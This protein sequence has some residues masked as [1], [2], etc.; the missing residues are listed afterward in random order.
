MPNVTITQLPAAG[1][2]TGTESVA[3]VQ[4]GQTL[5]TTT[6]AI[7][8]SPSQQQTFLTLNQEPTLPNSRALSGGAGVGLV[9]G[10]A[11]STLQVTL[12]GASGSLEAAANGVIV[13]TASNAVT[14]R[15]I[16]ATGPGISVTNGSGVAGDPTIALTGLALAI[17]NVGGTG[18]LSVVGGATIGGVQILG[19]AN[20]IDVA[21]GA[22]AGNPTIALAAN[23]VLPGTASMTVPVG[24]SAQQPAGLPGQLRFNA[25]TQ[26]FDGYALGQWRQFSVTGGVLT[27]SA[28]A[29]GLTPATPTSG[30]VTLGGILNAAH[31][32]T[33]VN[34]GAAT[35]TLGGNISTANDFIT[36]GA[37]ITLM[38]A[39]ATN[40]TLPT[41]GTLATL[42]GVEVLTN[43]TISGN[44]NT[45]TNI[46]NASLTNSSVTYNGVTVAL[47]A[48]GTITAATPNA[49]TFNDSGAG[50]AS[51]T[52]FDGSAART[53]S[54][55]TVGA[56]PLAGSVSLTTL[57]T[58]TTGTWNATPIGNSY[59]A[60]SAITIGTTSISLGG[61]SLTLGGLTSVAV[62][63]DPVSALQ[64]ATK[65]YV[66]A[67][68]EGLHV[69]AA[70]AAA[71]TGTLASITGGT[72]TYN[73]GSAGVG[74]TLTLSNALTTLDGYS[75][76]NGDRVLVK[77]EATTANNG[78]YT[79]A[80]GGTVLTRAPD[81][82][83]STEIAGGDFTFVTNGTLYGDTGWVQTDD[84][85]VVGTSP[86]TFIQF[87]GAGTYTAGTG[88]TLTGSQFSL[89]VPVTA[90]LGGTG[91]TS[92][93]T[94]DLLYATGATALSKLAIGTST[95]ILT[96]TGAAP[97]WSS[98]SGVTV[99]TATNLAGGAAGSVPYQ[100][101][102]GA[103]S[104][105]AIGTAA[106]VLQVNAGATAPE[107]VSS[108]GT[109]NV[110]R[111]TSPTL[112]TPLLGTPTSGTLTNCTG[113]PISTGVAGLGANVATFLATPTSAN[114]AAAVTNETGSGA[115]VFGTSP[116]IATPTLTGDVIIG[117]ENIYSLT[118]TLPTVVDDIVN[119]GS[120]ALSNGV[121]TFRISITVQGTNFPAA[122]EYAFAVRWDLTAGAW[123]M[124]QPLSD[125]G[126]YFGDDFVLEASV[127][128]GTT[129]LRLRRSLGTNAG[130]ATV[131]IT[132]GGITT[133]VFTPSTTTASVT[134]PTVFLDSAT[135]K[136]VN[137]NVGIGVEYPYARLHVRSNVTAQIGGTLALFQ[138]SAGAD[139]LYLVDENATGTKPAGLLAY[140][141]NYGLGYYSTTGPHIFYTNDP[142]VERL[143]ITTTGLVGIGVTTPSYSVSFDGT[144]VRS[145]GVERN[146]TADTAGR[147]LTLTA[148]GATSGGTNRNGGFL[149]LSG[150]TST[151]SG[152]S[153]I[154]FLTAASG[155]SGTAD[156]APAERMR[157]TGAGSLGIGTAS[158]SARLHVAEGAL[159]V[160]RTSSAPQLQLWSN[161]AAGGGT[162][163]LLN[164][165]RTDAGATATPDNSVIGEFRWDGRDTN[166]T[167]AL[168]A[169]ML[170]GI[171]VNAAGGGPGYITFNTAPSG[172]GVSE[173]LRITST[174]LI[175]VAVSNPSYQL[176][177]SGLAARTIGMERHTTANTAG[178]DLT[179][180]AGGATNVATDKNGGNLVLSAGTST[181][182]G[183]SAITFLTA[184]AGTAGTASRTPAE[185]VRIDG[186]GNVGV[187][188]ASPGYK[189]DVNGTAN[190]SG[191]ISGGTF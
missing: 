184:A 73:N 8:G 61:S 157:L 65:Q 53:I 102:A 30:V 88:L 38:A 32:G 155:A 113:L 44:N 81:F 43:K 93:S 170:V 160:S 9:D 152:S 51:G 70:C 36:S 127:S 47:G 22:G 1:P 115:L 72:V 39:G 29:T 74:A 148:G 187:G 132:K 166:N 23:P 98:A 153:I 20:Q 50:V 108:T 63:Q 84:V 34:N 191:G 10:G 67:V 56:S 173:R 138:N 125:G 52:T 89:T 174:G 131:I 45:L 151:G 117:S 46:A 119:I 99:G 116:T 49:A 156:N 123:Q 7:A 24:T 62:T 71:T 60:N 76:Q 147:N 95:T 111:D 13:K 83:T 40:V 26:T 91:Q 25:D 124:V 149:N 145:I 128:S 55:N 134:A 189:L 82:D 92:Y 163:C 161:Q 15:Q 162:Q 172:A 182:S 97:Q 18:L 54:Y 177:F 86:V 181:G 114:L 11:L 150:G 100:T 21:N 188:T 140:Y 121:A 16:T 69:H 120:F 94:G 107:W 186:S 5:R 171:G 118:R 4:N 28:D 159:I 106:Q 168:F 3:I 77:N 104:M 176:S 58:V 190:F 57:G 17:A 41:T 137:G 185:R 6:G 141:N 103:T 27:F 85:T 110:V 130:T 144:A 175:G 48:S 109:G 68:A 79:W 158:P 75:L 122:K 143:R 183:S 42:A 164:H 87:S 133:D 154:T 180:L 19:T 126:V 135:L 146:T 14:S 167:Y 136:Q 96:S 64:L 105:L 142:D 2:I 31:G 80:T 59:L 33:G 129:S 12:N 78:I 90:A 112:T 66:D 139:R 165:T 179:V 169:S 35:I 101:G 37:A 178:N